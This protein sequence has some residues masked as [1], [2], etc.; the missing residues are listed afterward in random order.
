[1]KIS[2]FALQTSINQVIINTVFPKMDII[3]PGGF[4]YVP[5]LFF[6]GFINEE[7]SF[8]FPIM[9]SVVKLLSHIESLIIWLD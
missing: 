7:L 5:C 4:V 6:G 3:S 1:M 8:A 2:Q 9:G